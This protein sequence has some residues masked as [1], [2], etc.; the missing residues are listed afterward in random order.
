M[1]VYGKY[2]E[3]VKK[4]R[5]QRTYIVHNLLGLHVQTL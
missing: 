1:T 3:V 5:I 2:T 4:F